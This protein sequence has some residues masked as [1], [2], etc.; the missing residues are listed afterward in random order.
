LWRRPLGVP[1]ADRA[2]ALALCVFATSTLA[3]GLLSLFVETFF[4]WNITAFLLLMPL[5]TGW[6]RRRWVLNLHYLYGVV[7]A[8]GLI[9]NNTLAPLANLTGGMDWTNAS[10]F[11]WSAVATR[12]TALEQNYPVGFVAA[13]RYTTAA[14]L[15]YA[16]RD[17]DVTAISDR[18]DQYDF[19][20][21]A[22]AHEGQDALVVSD[23]QIG[24]AGLRGHFASLTKLESVPYTAFGTEIYRPTIYL[25][26]G[27]S[28]ERHK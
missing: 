12:I 21:D 25:G 18:P 13:S 22:A 8:A 20:F 5:L 27:F 19:W 7:F 2:R 16:L 26:K 1:F 9:V 4:Y 6:V 11:G 10:T 28:A 14:Q 23:P 17:P 24:V 3:M 15:G